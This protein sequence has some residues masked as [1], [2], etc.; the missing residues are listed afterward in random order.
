LAGLS[1]AVRAWLP[2]GR[3]EPVVP[4]LP[5]D[6]RVV[7]SGLFSFGVPWPWQELQG[8]PLV[9]G[10]GQDADTEVLAL[11]GA[12]RTDREPAS[13]SV[14]AEDSPVD[15]DRNASNAGPQLARLYRGR[16]L[17]TER[18]AVAGCRAVIF[19]VVAGGHYVA[20]LVAERPDGSIQ[21]EFRVPAA[22][23]DGYLPHLYTMLGTW[24]WG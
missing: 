3:Y 14:W 7:S 10:D 6:F 9:D 18:V 24:V 22:H 2:G 23:I 5:V 17:G 8:G 1:D 16:L 11:I 12:P 4:R 21:G 20:R 15:L 19:G 13:F